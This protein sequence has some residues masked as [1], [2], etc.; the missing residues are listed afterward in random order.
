MYFINVKVELFL[1]K[2]ARSFLFDTPS[3]MFRRTVFALLA[4]TA[5]V[6]AADFYKVLGG[7]FYIV[8]CSKSMTSFD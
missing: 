7:A 5:L 3:T 6:V 4:L 8:L 2:D 1:N